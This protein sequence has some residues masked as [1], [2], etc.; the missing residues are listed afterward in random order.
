M[1]MYRIHYYLYNKII[2]NDTLLFCCQGLIYVYIFFITAH[3][4]VIL[5]HTGE[6]QAG[7]EKKFYFKGTVARNYL[8]RVFFM[9]ILYSVR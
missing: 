8:P 6:K 7:Y 4:Y 3:I 5:S 2:K 9:D 1:A